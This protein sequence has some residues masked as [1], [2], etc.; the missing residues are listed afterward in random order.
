MDRKK[1]NTKNEK[2]S[3]SRKPKS[4][5]QRHSKFSKSDSPRERSFSKPSE[6][7]T[8][9]KRPYSRTSG[10]EKKY[11]NK[12]KR[13]S[14]YAKPTEERT[15]EKRP[16]SR[17]SGD[18]KKY[19]NKFKKP[20]KYAKPAEERT[21]EK[22]PY[23]KDTDT[24]KKFDKKIR[25]PSSPRRRSESD[26]PYIAT[27]RLNRFLANAGICSRR[28]ADEYIKAGVVS[29][30]GKV[31]TEMGT[32]ITFAD[33]IR[34]NNELIR[35]E[36]KAYVLLNKPKDFITTTDDERGRKSVMQLIR[37]A[38]REKVYPIGRLDRNTTG[39]LLFTN[40]GELAAKLTHP[41]YAKKKIYHAH[42]DKKIKKEDMEKLVEG[43]VD[44]GETLKA[45]VVSIV[46]E[47]D[48]TQVGVEIHTGQNRVIRR[49][50]EALGYAVIKLDRVY[51]AGL[52]KKGLVRGAWRLLTPTEINMLKMGAFE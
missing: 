36:K 20:S 11:D 29:V 15:D 51:F 49:M 45:D 35:V 42:L 3:F 32:K 4:N 33:E 1:F 38:C 2:R 43:V 28:E 31:V 13:P 37:G 12:F 41:R 39:V 22:R 16:Y 23:S 26:K 5:D 8:D 6:E 34:F 30:N 27:W 18:E 19:D 44:K 52:T 24:G 46:D 48:R 17:T 14:K 25:R 7:R 50:F 47:A 40:D 9:E 10:D 21:D